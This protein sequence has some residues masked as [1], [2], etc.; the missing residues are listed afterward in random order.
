MQIDGF[1]GA[2]ITADHPDYDAARAV[3]N[4]SV[5]RRPRVIARCTGAA[6]AAAAVRFARAQ[7]LEIAVRG[8][9]QRRRHRC[10]RRRPRR[11]PLGDA[12]RV[13]RS[14]PERRG[15]RVARCGA[16]STT[17]RRRTASP[18]PAAS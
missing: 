11:R 14:R 2:L 3:W 6:D 9:A 1:R 17:R 16:T 13:G 18:P 10:V 4:G 15:C 8:R 5:D 7:D 12:G